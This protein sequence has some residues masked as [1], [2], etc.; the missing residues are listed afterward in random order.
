MQTSFSPSINIERD[1]NRKLNYIPTSNSIDIFNQIKNNYKLGIHAFNIIGSYGTGKSSFILAFEKNLKGENTYFEQINGQFNNVQKFKFLNIVGEYKSIHKLFSE[2]L[3]IQENIDKSNAIIKELDKTYKKLHSENSGLVIVIDEFG[4]IL[5]F[6]AQNEPE[7]ELYFIQQLAEYANNNQ[8]NILLF[9]ILHQNFEAYATKLN[10]TQKNE[11]EKVKGR[12]KDLTFNEP[13]EQLLFLASEF[14]SSR[15]FLKPN[16]KAIVQL[17]KIIESSQ[18][19]LLKNELTEEYAKK[20]FPLDLLSASVLTL[21]LQAYGQNERSLFTF[22][23]SDD[24]FGINQFKTNGNPFYNLSCVYDYLIHNFYSFLSTRNNPHYIQWAAIKNSLERIESNI[25]YDYKNAQNIVKAIGLL[26]IFSSEAARINTE[27]LSAYSEICLGIK[28]TTNLLEELENKK[29]IRYINFKDRFILFEGTD[30]DIELAI[31]QAG[32]KIEPIK[33]I[34]SP[35]KK[36]F[37]FPYI[38]AK[39]VQ[40]NYG[41]PRYFEFIISD[42]PISQEPVGEIDGIINLVFPKE[43]K[44]GYIQK[45]SIE[46]NQSIIYGIYNNTEKIKENLFEIEKIKYVLNHIADDRIAERELKNILAHHIQKLNHFVLSDLYS[47]NNKIKWIHKKKSI[48]FSDGSSFNNFLSKICCEV[49]SG[50]PKFRNEL[51]NK[52]KTSSQITTAR[53]NFFKALIKDWQK[54]NLNFS[55][56]KYPPEKTIY[57]SLL[58]KTGIHLTINKDWILSAPEEDSFKNLWNTSEE[59]LNSAKIVKKNLKEFFV[60]LSQKP[61]K[62]KNGFIDFWVPLFLFIRREEYALFNENGFI[63]YLDV[64]IIEF[65]LKNPHKF[66]IKSFNIKGVQLDLF[67]KYRALLN[68]NEK[69][70]L[71]TSSF[72]NTIKPFLVFYRDLPEYSKRT[73]RLSKSS[74]NLRTAI[75]N[76]TDPEESFFED[77]PSALGYHNFNLRKSEEALSG[78]IFQ[79]QSSIREIRS[80]FEELINRIESHLKNETGL[81]NI[82]FP[83]YKTNLKNRYNSI[84]LS[85]LLP[86]Q[87]VF[88]SRI[89]SEL[90]DRKAWISSLIQ[91]VL[92]KP[93]E[94]MRDEEEELSLE[95]ISNSI[96]ELDNLCDI[97]K[98]DFDKE[99]E[100]ILKFEVTDLKSGVKRNIVRLPNSKSNQVSYLRKRI[101]S[102]LTTDKSINLVALTKMIEEIENG[103]S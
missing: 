95:K 56:E 71:S 10:R 88:Y 7:K 89:V 64:D 103:K 48:E 13:V 44:D 67:N 37:D 3:N 39:S 84:K 2:R 65:I 25:E 12:L 54:E 14:I 93:I 34:V 57:L 45:K 23:E 29:I 87:K 76:A 31:K 26:S 97:S 55:E 49:Y 85:L 15:D 100:E 30:L 35:I 43:K 98:I 102:L 41:T 9:T 5:E 78:Y 73:K 58:K 81:E 75:A 51:I 46:Q 60:I 68:K 24:K 40:Y 92:E 6:A 28:N 19:F 20:L 77:F 86:H 42:T 32:E 62:L 80:C 50:T 11:W 38:P 52:H 70:K 99:K 83:K 27:F 91:A 66:Q 22:L 47:N 94:E 90:D 63:P 59:F 79:L 101:R 82:S 36:Y 33:D 96:H 53:K 1:K 4:K 72:I 74:L 18:T 16:N 21:S 69:D 61:L 17:N 8:K